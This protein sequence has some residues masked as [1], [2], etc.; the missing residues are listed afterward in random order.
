MTQAPQRRGQE[1]RVLEPARGLRFIDVREL[2]RYRGLLF[3]LAARDV[4]VRYKQTFLGALWAFLQPFLTMLI[5]A[6]LFGALLPRGQLPTAE[7]VP[8]G[9]S[10]LAALVPWFLFQNGVS[11]ASESLVASREMITKVYFP[12]A[13]APLSSLVAASVDFFV[14][15]L[16]L[17]VLLGFFMVQGE[18]TLDPLRALLLPAFFV[19]GLAA[20]LALSLWLAALNALYRDVKH[21]VPFLLRL[22][23]FAT[24]T[25][26]T[27]ASIA[28]ALPAWAKTLYELNP[29]VP[30]VE[31]FRWALLPAAPFPVALPGALLL[32]LVLLVGGS[33][34]FRWVEDR[35]VDVI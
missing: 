28:D 17:A 5:F 35:L 34:F 19:L 29:M 21:A 14:G 20:A 9:L 2:W 11:Q 13:L 4:R 1:L 26:Y 15:L 18:A 23:M 3:E 27:T 22:W 24:P 31:G 12:R 32:T 30:V 10:T 16:S 25:V 33:A 7:G 8:Y 6:G